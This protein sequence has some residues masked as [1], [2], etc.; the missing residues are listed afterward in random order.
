MPRWV[1]TTTANRLC[2]D[3]WDNRRL[4]VILEADDSAAARAAV[5]ARLP[6]IYS[7]R[8]GWQDRAVVNVFEDVDPA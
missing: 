5:E 2:R 7:G 4:A 3:V 6:R 1:V 8:E